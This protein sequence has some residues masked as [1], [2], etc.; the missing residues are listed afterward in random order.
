MKKSDREKL[1]QIARKQGVLR[2]ADAKAAGYHSQHI[3]RLVA[4][5]VLERIAPGCYLHADRAVTEHHGLVTVAAAAPGGVV[6][7]LSALSFHGIGT[8]LPGDVW[9]AIERGTRVPIVEWPPVTLMRFSGAAFS[10]GIDSHRIAGVNVRVYSVAKTL[11][12]VFRFRNRVGLD[13]ALEAL[14]DAWRQKRFTVSALERAARACRVERV[15]RPY[16]EA[17]MG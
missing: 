1:V 11:A 10:E 12:D 13:V 4:D 6:C 9:L 7:L 2:A 14:R 16:I 17:I 5:R 3:T 8:Q 15:M